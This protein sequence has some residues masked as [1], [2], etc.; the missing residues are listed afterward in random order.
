[1][2][3]DFCRTIIA[4]SADSFTDRTS[5][6]FIDANSLAASFNQLNNDI[7]WFG[8]YGNLDF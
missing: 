4:K 7:G 3:I 1:M 6:S 2:S 5:S 8:G